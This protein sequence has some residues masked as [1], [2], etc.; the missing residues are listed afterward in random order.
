MTGD[1]TRLLPP[2]GRAA[3]MGILNITPDSFSDGGQFFA[4]GKPDLDRV[5][6]HA[7][8]MVSDGVDIFDV[9][10][11]STRPGAPA[12]AAVEELARVVPVVAMLKARFGVPVSVDTSSPEVIAAVAAEGADMIN[13]V[14]AL[15]RPGALE[16]AAHSGLPVCLMHTRGEP[17][18]MQQLARYEDVVAEVRQYLRERV[19]LCRASGIGAERI[20]IDPG[21][22]FAKTLDHNLALFRA[23]DDF[24]AEGLPVLVG[25]S[26][27]RMVGELLG[28]DLGERLPGS[29]ALALL[30]VQQ[31][32]RIL[33]VHDVAA[34]VDVVKILDA[35]NGR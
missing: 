22:G 5:L 18:R 13:D 33:R 4:A 15:S 25:V 23:L 19:A 35:F 20:A 31:G 9:G 8:A 26:R 14:R 34:T 28:R 6:S 3:V 27:K 24:V 1:F 12:V 30:A 2:S 7:E 10:G 29:L 11:E 17:A 21:F 16:A 32:V